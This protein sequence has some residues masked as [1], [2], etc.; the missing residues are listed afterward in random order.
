[1]SGL[2]PTAM[3]FI[4]LALRKEAD[5]RNSS[6]WYSWAKSP[7][8]E[9][10]SYVAQIAIHALSSLALSLEKA[11]EDGKIDPRTAAEFENDLGYIAAV[12]ASLTECL[13]TP[14]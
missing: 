5:E 3:R 7:D 8:T 1:M 13:L 11:I 6:R 12:E 9:M 4:D 2:S 14:V 10:P